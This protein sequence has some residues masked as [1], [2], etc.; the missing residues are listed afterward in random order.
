M[1]GENIHK[2]IIVVC[3]VY[4]HVWQTDSMVVKVTKFKSGIMADFA[5]LINGGSVLTEEEYNA[6][7]K[8]K[9]KMR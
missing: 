7:T 8:S 4:Y 9:K 2:E 1:R 5:Q 6:I 3:M